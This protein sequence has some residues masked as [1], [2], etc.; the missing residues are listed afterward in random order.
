MRKG[1]ILLFLLPVMV[2]AKDIQVGDTIWTNDKLKKVDRAE[3]TH[4]GYAKSVDTTRNVAT[5]HY[6]TIEEPRLVAIHHLVASGESIG[7]KKGK[8]LRFNKDGKV[9]SLM[10]YTLVY[11]E[12]KD[13]YRSRLA[14][15]TLSYPDGSTQEEL[16]LD[17]TMVDGKEKRTYVRNCYYPDGRLRYKEINDGKDL[18]TTYY[19]ETGQETKNPKERMAYYETMPSYPGGEEALFE[20]L[21]RS[22]IYPKVAK[23]N[24]IQGRV[25]VGFTV[26]VDG[27]ITN[28]KVLRSGGDPSL[29]REAKR[30]IQSMPRWIPGKIRG[31]PVRIKYTVPVNFR[32]D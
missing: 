13:K 1:F 3:A 15:E 20:Y 16:T 22:V 24:H 17:Y 7:F 23:D 14:S 30:V 26:D 25:I 11:D 8:Q 31:E 2:M 18:K 28:V 21:K 4:Y 29:D 5:I 32:F 27:H 6:Y 12:K 19:D 9:E 10:I